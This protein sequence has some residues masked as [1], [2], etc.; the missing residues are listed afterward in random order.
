MGE[1]APVPTSNLSRLL[2]RRPTRAFEA[3]KRSPWSRRDIAAHWLFTAALMAVLG[4]Y[5]WSRMLLASHVLHIFAFWLGFL[6]LHMGL[7]HILCRALGGEG[8]RGAGATVAVVSWLPILIGA[9]LLVPPTALKGFEHTL[10]FS[11]PY[12]GIPPGLAFAVWF[13][14]LQRRG[15]QVAYGLSKGRARLAVAL[16]AL[17]FSAM[18]LVPHL[19]IQPDVFL[20]FTE[21]RYAVPGP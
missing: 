10:L 4:S 9:L 13:F 6:A 7:L 19:F 3:L 1:A 5:F 12:A 2:V 14:A 8:S 15:V 20:F 18:L 16:L 17:L 21:A 11:E